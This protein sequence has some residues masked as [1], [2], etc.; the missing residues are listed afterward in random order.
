MSRHF[1]WELLHQSWK[2]WERE[3]GA[4]VKGNTRALANTERHGVLPALVS[5]V[6]DFCPLIF[7]LLKIEV[8]EPP[9]LS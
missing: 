6:E 1:L 7:F 9:H 3:G 2:Q 5:E 8:T 4:E